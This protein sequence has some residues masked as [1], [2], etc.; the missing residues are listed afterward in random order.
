[1]V[2]QLGKEMRKYVPP[3]DEFQHAFAVAR[4]SQAKLARYYLDRLQRRDDK[5]NKRRET[6][7]SDD[8]TEL[9]LEHVIPLNCVKEKWPDLQRED[10]EA[11]YGRIGNM[12][13]LDAVKNSKIGNVGFAEKK[14]AFANSMLSLTKMVAENNSWGADEVNKRQQVLAK[15]AVETWPLRAS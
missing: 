15:L 14:Q 11:L 1:M 8:T 12:A 2:E 10:A 4:V 5:K 7:P 13:L 9:N 6:M 3:N